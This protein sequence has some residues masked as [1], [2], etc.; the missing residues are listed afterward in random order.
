MSEQELR[1]ALEGMCRQFAFWSKGSLWHG[2]LSALEEAFDVL[3]W[4]DLHPCPDMQCDEPGC[5]EQATCGVPTPEGY[6]HMCSK[7][8]QKYREKEGK[9]Q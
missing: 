7:D 6:R 9:P 8:A 2:G 4:G 1:E 5:T 3:G